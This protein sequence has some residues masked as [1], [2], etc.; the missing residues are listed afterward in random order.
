MQRYKSGRMDHFRIPMSLPTGI[1]QQRCSTI[2][3]V[4]YGTPDCD[5]GYKN[6][7]YPKRDIAS[8]LFWEKQLVKLLK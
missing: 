7:R 2:H 5:S 6:G 3:Q 1:V 4:E 8:I